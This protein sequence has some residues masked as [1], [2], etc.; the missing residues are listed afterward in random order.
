[1]IPEA[2]W[3]CPGILWERERSGVSVT[4]EQLSELQKIPI[5]ELRR[6]ELSDANEVVIDTSKSLDQRV[7][8]FFGQVKNPF[9]QNVGEYI[10]Q[11]GY[12]EG[13]QETL[14]DRMV[15]LVRKQTAI[16]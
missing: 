16:M 6:E 11:I 12:A 14:D 5:M 15:Q 1:M 2:K 9:A 3:F 8:S 4:M 7:Q 13:V 10:L